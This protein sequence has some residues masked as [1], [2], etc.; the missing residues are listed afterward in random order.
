MYGLDKNCHWHDN[1]AI[2]LLEREEE[3]G[4]SLSKA[5]PVEN[6]GHFLYNQ[7]PKICLEEVQA[8]MNVKKV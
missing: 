8:F 1:R 6:A 7:Q 5:I 3:E 4:R 2:K